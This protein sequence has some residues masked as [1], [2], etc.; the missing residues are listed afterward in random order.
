VRFLPLFLLLSACSDPIEENLAGK[1]VQ[2]EV[3]ATSDTC[4]PARF[5]GDAGVQF[6]GQRE[7][8]GYLFTM[9]R[10]AQL[11]PNED[12]GFVESVDR[13]QVPPQNDLAPLSACNAQ[14]SNWTRSD[15][16]FDLSQAF[17]GVKSCVNGPLWLPSKDCESN[18]SFLMTELGDCQLKCVHLSVSGEVTCSC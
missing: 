5:V 14:L 6:F 12:G 4:L 9:S 8:G 7:D 2:V 1:L 18:R 13:Q 16:G 15:A 10:N 3:V 17:P 11:G